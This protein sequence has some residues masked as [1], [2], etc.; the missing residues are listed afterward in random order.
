M[1]NKSANN[2]ALLYSIVITAIVLITIGACDIFLKLKINWGLTLLIVIFC[3]FLSY[4]IL[5]VMLFSFVYNRIKLIYKTI[6]NRKT[7]SQKKFSYKTDIIK[8]VEKDVN[9]WAEEQKEK[10]GKIIEMNNYRKEFI[11]NVSHELKTPIFNIQGYT[12]TLLEGGLEDSTINKKYLKKIDKNIN[13][14]ISII[15]DL[16]VITKLESSQLKLKLKEFNPIELC[17]DIIETV[18]EYAIAN[19][20]KIEIIKHYDKQYNVSAD[21]DFIGQV[22][23]NL[24]INAINY[25]K[26]NG[27]IKIEFYDM[28]K[29]IL[30]EITDNGIGIPEEDIPRI[31]ERFYRVDKSRSLSSGGSGLGLAIVKNIIE[32]HEQSVNISSSLGIGTTVA[33]TLKIEK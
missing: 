13:R 16:D 23:T 33:F 22:Y 4:F 9:I 30:V 31:F 27:L 24:L 18:E 19:K 6:H 25:N 12:I 5:R 21:Y 17:K 32:A 7:T 29:N 28:D 2:L 3:F 1:K 10:M 8:Q 14:M 15:N 26:Q 11:G 20:I